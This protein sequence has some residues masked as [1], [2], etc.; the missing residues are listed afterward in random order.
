MPSDQLTREFELPTLSDEA[1]VEI[2][3]L[4]EV[5]I[6]IFA[7]RY[8]RQIDRHYNSLSEHNIVQIRPDTDDPPF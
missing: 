1:A 8:G 5:A 2:Q 6:D 7:A 3:N 4:L